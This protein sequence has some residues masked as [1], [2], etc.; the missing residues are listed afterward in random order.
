M[1]LPRYQFMTVI[2]QNFSP[3]PY[4]YRNTI[5]NTFHSINIFL[6]SFFG[7]LKYHSCVTTLLMDVIQIQRIVQYENIIIR[8]KLN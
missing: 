3:L 2:D 6:C 4:M 8:I 5:I 7:E 1:I